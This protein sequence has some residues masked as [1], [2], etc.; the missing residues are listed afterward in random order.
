L[1]LKHNYPV[2]WVFIEHWPLLIL[3]PAVLLLIAVLTLI[4][5]QW[6]QRDEIAARESARRDDN[7]VEPL[8][9]DRG[10]HAVNA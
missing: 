6:D 5:R 1:N 7:R 8:K 9:A 10:E 4:T 2:L 3:T